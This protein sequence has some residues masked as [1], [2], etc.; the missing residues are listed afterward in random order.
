MRF[1]TACAFVLEH[2]QHKGRTIA[3]VGVTGEGLL[4]LAWLQGRGSGNSLELDTALGAYFSDHSIRTEL[5]ELN[6]TSR[7][8]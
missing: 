3:D 6:G 7:H 4:Y 2:G 5:A 1:E 8:E